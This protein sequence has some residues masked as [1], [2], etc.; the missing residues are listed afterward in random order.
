[1]KKLI[2]LSALLLGACH[3][4]TEP[5]Q[6]ITSCEPIYMPLLTPVGDTLWYK[7]SELYCTWINTRTGQGGP[8]R[9]P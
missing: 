1:M 6:I 9:H 3:S 8:G 7:T 4:P 5:A 2:L